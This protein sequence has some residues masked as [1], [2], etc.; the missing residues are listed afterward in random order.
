MS[1]DCE[2]TRSRRVAPRRLL[3][4]AMVR[5]PVRLAMYS[6]REALKKG[7]VV[8]DRLRVVGFMV[9]VVVVVVTGGGV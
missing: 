2:G 8:L 7:E 1:S 3:P 9:V 6:V 5:G 4:W